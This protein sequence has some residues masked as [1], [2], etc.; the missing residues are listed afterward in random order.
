M[1]VYNTAMVISRGVTVATAV[2]AIAIRGLGFWGQLWLT[3]E[4]IG[5]TLTLIQVPFWVY[6]IKISFGNLKEAYV[7][8]KKAVQNVHNSKEVRQEHYEKQ[9]IAAAR[10]GL[11]KAKLVKAGRSTRNIGFGLSSMKA[12]SPGGRNSTAVLQ[13]SSTGRVADKDK[14]VSPDKPSVSPSGLGQLTVCAPAAA[15]PDSQLVVL[16]PLIPPRPRDM[17]TVFSLGPAKT[18]GAD[19]APPPW[20]RPKWFQH[21][22]KVATEK[23][24]VTLLQE[25]KNKIVSSKTFAKLA[26]SG[27]VHMAN[28]NHN[29]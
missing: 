11:H 17:S 18:D 25:K 1:D 13:L 26:L 7:S 21:Y 27:S 10:A 28:I 3:P 29:V 6:L 23:T 16:A 20:V 5:Y 2:M 14:A 22:Q 24:A 15:E 8:A 12:S 19:P 4:V 9:R